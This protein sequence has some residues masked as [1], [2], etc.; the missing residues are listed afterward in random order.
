MGGS[1]V[2]YTIAARAMPRTY[3]LAALLL[4]AQAAALGAAPQLRGA[5]LRPASARAAVHAMAGGDADSR[6]SARRERRASKRDGTPPAVPQPAPAP[7]QA[8][9]MPPPQPFVAAPYDEL[10]DQGPKVDDAPAVSLPS[11][12]DFRRRDAES[13]AVPAKDEVFSF[14]PGN[15]PQFSAAALAAKGRPEPTKSSEGLME[16]LS[17]DT[18]DER[19]RN[20][21]VYDTTARIIGRGLPNKAGAYYLPYL[22]TGHMLLVGVLLLSST[23]S[24]PGFPLTEVLLIKLIT[25]LL[26]LVLVL[27]YY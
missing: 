26:L 7:A 4:S 25:T 21:V 12:D 23:I 22:Q 16:L 24:Y 27:C 9:A 17:F 20:E 1:T 14:G 13:G 18:I 15:T 6:R 3:A 10:L 5:M 19:P 11:F 8:Q 2:H